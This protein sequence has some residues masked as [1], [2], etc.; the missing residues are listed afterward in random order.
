MSFGYIK[1][2][3]RMHTY[4][5]ITMQDYIEICAKE[6]DSLIVMFNLHLHHG[7]AVPSIGYTDPACGVRFTAGVDRTADKYQVAADSKSASS[8]RSFPQ[9]LL[10]FQFN[11][12]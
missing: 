3:C 6:F 10:N 4:K 9:L 8:L 2:K 12:I 5:V 11:T 1:L 7:L